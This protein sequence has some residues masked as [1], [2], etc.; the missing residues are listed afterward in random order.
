MLE[1]LWERY[2][3]HFSP[4]LN[5]RIEALAAARPARVAAPRRRRRPTTRRAAV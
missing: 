1:E 4:Y 3:G 2:R 5:A